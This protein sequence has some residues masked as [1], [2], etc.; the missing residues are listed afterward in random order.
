MTT[1]SPLDE[2]GIAMRVARE[3]EDG[4]Y[5]IL[6]GGIPTLVP[7]FIPPDKRVLFQS[8]NGILGY[9]PSA[10]EG[11]ED[12]DLF[13]TGLYI[14]LMPGAAFFHQADAFAMIRGGH[15][16]VTVMGGLQVSEKGDLANWRFPERR[17]GGMGGAMDLVAGAKRLIIA[18][19]HTTKDGKPKIVRECTF[20]L[21]GK[22]CVHRII[23]DLAVI[24]ITRD[25]LILREV[26][27][28]F[29]AEEV[30]SLTEARLKVSDDLKEMEP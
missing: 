2:N 16:D 28:G 14:N 17:A 3:L 22:A 9:G 23:T 8:E 26:A 29:T 1:K 18:M 15:H 5:V 30:Q 13:T 19:H 24:D 10:P 4:S 27:P 21:T 11:E 7:N 25:G 12:P 6:G 20:P